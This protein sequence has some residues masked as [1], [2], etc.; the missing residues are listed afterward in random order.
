MR[1]TLVFLLIAL[2]ASAAD[3]KPGD[4]GTP[5]FKKATELVKQLGHTRYATREAAAKQLLDMGG[6][7]VPALTAG[8]R[9]ED[10]EVRTRCI[11]L[12]PHA[13]AADWKRRA[14][15]FLADV[16]GKDKHDLPLLAEYSTAV[17]KLNAGSRKLFADMVRTNGELLA[18]A[19]ADP[20]AAK[21]AV[22]SRCRDLL[23]LVR[24]GQ[25]QV[26]AD[27]GDLAALFFVH[28]RVS[29]DRADWQ[30][31]DHPAHLLA[32]P[33][34]AEG[35][36]AADVGPVL[37]QVVVRWVEG[38]PPDDITSH[39]FFVIAVRQKPFPEAVPVLTRLA[40][41]KNASIFNVRALAIEA[42]GKVGNKEAIA[43]LEELMSDATPLFRGGRGE[44]FQLGD[45]AFA[46]LVSAQKK[47]PEDYGLSAGLS[48]GL[49]AAAQGETIILTLQSFP[50]N[51]ARQK[52]L[53]K[54][55]DEA[56]KK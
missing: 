15:A 47:K 42:L 20:K 56:A 27:V 16:D 37:R 48:I 54:W 12:L 39:Q 43:A 34:L 14:A 4:E 5:E 31:L 18:Q 41:D 8:A 10:E 25:K 33:A 26:P 23:G 11:A 49:R 51:D 35:V 46:A 52:G 24:V 44:D 3:P 22:T 30:G 29:K 17:G 32:N 13:K 2:P 1:R 45:S 19:A 9:S 21:A 7:A 36:G 53:K 55:K 50:N 38:Q 6:A 28:S 40:K